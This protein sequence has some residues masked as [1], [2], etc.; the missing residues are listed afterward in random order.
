M[1]IQSPIDQARAAYS[2]AVAAFKDAR[3]RV[4]E[5]KREL[6]RLEGKARTPEQIKSNRL[7]QRRAQ[8]LRSH[9]QLRG[10]TNAAKR[11]DAVDAILAQR[12]RACVWRF[13]LDDMTI[14]PETRAR[15]VYRQRRERFELYR[16]GL[17]LAAQMM[18]AKRTTLAGHA[19]L[20]E[21]N[22]LRDNARTLDLHLQGLVD[23]SPRQVDIHYP[24][25]W[26]VSSKALRPEG[27]SPKSPGAQRLLALYQHI[28][29]T[30]TV[31]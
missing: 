8:V 19:D 1:S 2:A 4:T 25:E 10:I 26:R 3:D 7:S 31:C 18:R 15:K 20:P 13:Y 27:S 22:E 17:K 5:A 28:V 9:P 29:R 30:H 6:A 24:H 11:R 23:A 14:D 16:A 21:A 12:D